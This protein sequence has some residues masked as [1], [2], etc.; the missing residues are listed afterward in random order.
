MIVPSFRFVRTYVH[1]NP[2]IV[3]A[4]SCKRWQTVSPG[5]YCD[6]TLPLYHFM[7][8]G[9][10]VKELELGVLQ[11]AFDKHGCCNNPMVTK[12]RLL[13]VFDC[14][15]LQSCFLSSVEESSV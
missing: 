8:S 1:R 2:L 12:L 14:S 5:P 7:R 15:P 13:R 6:E 4:G 10:F 11:F 9:L 3:F